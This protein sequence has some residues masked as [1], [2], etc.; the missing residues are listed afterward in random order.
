M[1]ANCD[2]GT[3]GVDSGSELTGV[4]RSSVRSGGAGEILSTRGLRADREWIAR[5][6]RRAAEA[7]FTAKQP[8]SEPSV[9]ASR[10]PGDRKQ[11]QGVQ[12]R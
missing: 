12:R 5:R 3:S 4:L 10:Q 11:R 7:L 8:V 2:I 6:A 1:Q 9:P